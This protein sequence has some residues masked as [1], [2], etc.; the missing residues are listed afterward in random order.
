[1]LRL[2][3]ATADD[4][5]AVPN[6]ARRGL[7]ASGLSCTL[8]GGVRIL[9]DIDLHMHP[10]RLTA[11]VGPNGSGKSTLLRC[12]AR[13]MPYSGEATLNGVAL[14]VG[15]RRAFARKLAFLPQ[16]PTAPDGATVRS[17]AERGR[18]PHRRGF[19]PLS[20]ADREIVVAV[21]EACGVAEL[22]QREVSSLSGGQAQ[23]AWIAMILAQDTDTIL[24]DEP[25]AF[26]DLAH[27]VS[28]LQSCRELARRGRTV[29]VVLHDLNLAAAFADHVLLINKGRLRAAGS[30]REVFTESVLASEFDLE[31]Q[32]IEDPL[33]SAPVIL[34][35]ASAP[36]PEAS[37][38][39]HRKDAP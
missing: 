20:A 21:L 28:L 38:S 31:C 4:G 39:P 12:L 37:N 23:R 9:R 13:Q 18:E 10:A 1:M 11:I 3:S 30:P 26:L 6:P 22:A 5:E 35:R 19:R 36:T 17:L 2:T 29:V 8:A 7:R 34:P 14:G 15:S 24:L 16:S 27:Q 25:T 32:V 33:S